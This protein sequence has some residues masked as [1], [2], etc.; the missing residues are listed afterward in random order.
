[1]IEWDNS[2]ISPPSAK[3][4]GVISIALWTMIVVFGRFIAYNWFDPLV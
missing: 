3:A 4:A 2:P 1:L